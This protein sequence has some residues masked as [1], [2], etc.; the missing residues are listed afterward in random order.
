MRISLPLHEAKDQEATGEETDR[1]EDDESHATPSNT[2]AM[3]S[4]I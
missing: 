2:R 1:R 4:K 3:A